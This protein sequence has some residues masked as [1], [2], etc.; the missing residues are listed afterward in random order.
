MFSPVLEAK[1]KVFQSFYPSGLND[2][3]ALKMEIVTNAKY[4]IMD[5]NLILK[6][7]QTHLESTLALSF[8]F[9]N[10]ALS[11]NLEREILLKSMC[12]SVEFK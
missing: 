3:V 6:H 11:W 5:M 1:K 7:I 8:T 12:Q 2:L 4:F 9:N 10:I